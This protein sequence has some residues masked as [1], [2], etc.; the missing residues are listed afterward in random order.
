MYFNISFIFIY[1]LKAQHAVF[2]WGG[3][4]NLS[5]NEFSIKDIRMLNYHHFCSTT[6][7]EQKFFWYQNVGY[8]I[9]LRK[10]TNL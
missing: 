1:L 6:L 9:W 8:K 2:V 5:L 7:N 10:H 4:R 3:G